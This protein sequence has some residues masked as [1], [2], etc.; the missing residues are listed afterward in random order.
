MMAYAIVLIA[1]VQ[2][3]SAGS[4]PVEQCNALQQENPQTL[5]VDVEPNCGKG[6]AVP[7]LG[8]AEVKPVKKAKKVSARRRVRR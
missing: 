2:F 7:C 4:I 3:H 8:V 1:G 6:E 5:C